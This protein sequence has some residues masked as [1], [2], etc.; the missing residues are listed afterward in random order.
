MSDIWAFLFAS[1]FL[2][3]I[4]SKCH[5]I[6]PAL[7]LALAAYFR[8]QYAVSGYLFVLTIA[9]WYLKNQGHSKSLSIFSKDSFSS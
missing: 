1:I 2:L 4:N 5:P 6:Y 9:I 8:A 7:A 3:L